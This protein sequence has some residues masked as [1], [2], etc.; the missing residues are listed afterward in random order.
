MLPAD[1]VTPPLLSR[2]L[3]LY[4][5]VAFGSMTCFYLLLSVVPLYATAVGAGRVGA[6]MTTAVLMLATVAAELATPAL[7]AWLGY[8]VVLGTGLILLGLPALGLIGTRSLTMILAVSVVRGVGLAILVVAGSALVATLVPRER[9]SEGIGLSGV[10]VGVPAVLALPLG[11]WL[12]GRIGFTPV[13]VAGAVAALVSLAALPA[14][15]GRRAERTP[16]VGM[17]AGLRSAGQVR[18][19]LLFLLTALGAGIVV[20]FLPL[21]TGGA[22]VDTAPVALF[23]NAVATTAARWWSGRQGDR[24]GQPRLLVLGVA[25]CAVG[26]AILAL[27]PGAVPVVAGA[28][29]LGLGFGA[30]QNASLSLMFERVPA[31]GYGMVSAIWNLAY[32]A[33]MGLGAASFGVL[34]VRT[35][36]AGAFLAVGLLL[37][38]ALVPVWRDRAWLAAR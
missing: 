30:A 20:T 36:Y 6:G 9:R 12:S 4:F 33:G 14:L 31:S 32:D 15:P 11:V 19:A 17:L 28:T 7:V 10:V 16:S 3:S 18:P 34:A 21:V 26:M 5:I 24:H 1:P 37:L 8:R 22:G 35:G 25:A 2:P 23:V 27:G 29:L 38:L 13:F